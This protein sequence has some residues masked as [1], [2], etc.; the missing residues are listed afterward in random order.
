MTMATGEKVFAGV[1]IGGTS[2]KVGTV[3]ARGKILARAQ[4]AY[5]PDS[6]H[7]QD[8]VDLATAVL[9]KLLC[10]ENM[11]LGDVSGESVGC[12]SVV[13][14][15]G[16]VHAGSALNWG[17]V[18]LQRMF[19]DRLNKPVTVCN[20]ADAAV[21]AEQWVGSAKGDIKTFTMLTLGTGVGFGAVINGQLARGGQNI[22][23][24]GHLIVERN[25]RLCSC[26]QTG[27]LEAYS[28]GGAL[29]ARVKE[30]LLA[31]KLR[32]Y[33]NVL[34]HSVLYRKK[35]SVAGHPDSEIAE[36]IFKHA[37]DGDELCKSLVDEAAD[38]MSF[39]C[40]NYARMMDPEVIVLSGGVAE[41]GEAYIE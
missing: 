30:N 14:D 19:A 17:A 20:D 21:L 9:D 18:P 38:S 3:T 26:T 27:C 40:V 34:K 23:E 39:A 15:C 37:A 22:V 7:P 24:G 35:S 29:V 12:P 5:E 16:V 8:V 4:E 10:K 6:R 32:C 41:A 2:V 28:S 33:S 1:D 13:E 25:G 31:G 36:V 11:S